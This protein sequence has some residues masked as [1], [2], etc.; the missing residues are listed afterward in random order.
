MKSGGG[1]GGGRSCEKAVDTCLT[2]HQPWAS[3]LVHGI[4]RIEGRSWPAPLRGRLWIHAASKVPEPETIRAM[5]NFYKEIYAVNGITDI[6]F[7]HQYPVSRL[8]GCVEVVGCLRS[9]DLVSWD[10]VP[11]SVRL[12]GLTDFCWLCENPQKLKFPLEMRGNRGVYILENWIYEAAMRAL[13][14]IEGPLPVRFPLPNP[15][16]P[17]SSKPGSVSPSSSRPSGASNS[18]TVSEAIAGARA[19]ATQFTKKDE[20]RNAFREQKDR[21]QKHEL[22]YQKNTAA[23]EVCR[24]ESGMRESRVREKNLD[25]K[26]AE[27][28]QTCSNGEARSHRPDAKCPVLRTGSSKVIVG[29]FSSRVSRFNSSLPHSTIRLVL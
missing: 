20:N 2:M 22:L 4:K 23:S 24:T 9:E 27:K 7:P 29:D 25:P 12:E 5:E 28:L 11:E 16:D 17:F 19:A 21:I 3:L 10:A 26:I 13:I 14:P 1:G 15:Q 8:L 18:P 6:K